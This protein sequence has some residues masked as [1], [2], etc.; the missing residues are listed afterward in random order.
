MPSYHKKELCPY[1]KQNEKVT[2]SKSCRDCAYNIKRVIGNVKQETPD[3]VVQKN[4][5]YLTIMRKTA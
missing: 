1:C 4:Q 2:T 3:Q 5:K